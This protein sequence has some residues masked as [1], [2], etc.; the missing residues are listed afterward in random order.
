MK[1]SKSFMLSSLQS[2]LLLQLM[3]SMEK[4]YSSQLII[5]KH[6]T[7]LKKQNSYLA[8]IKVNKVLCFMCDIWTKISSNNAVPSRVVFLVKFFLDIS[9]NILFKIRR[10][11]TNKINLK[12]K[13]KVRLKIKFTAKPSQCCIF[14]ELA[15][16]SRQRLVACPLTCLR[17]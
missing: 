3:R 14:Q 10:K 8:Q 2:L 13:L 16:H 12:V 9:S 17:F 15:R 11:T 7:R 4:E 1:S 5:S 6:L